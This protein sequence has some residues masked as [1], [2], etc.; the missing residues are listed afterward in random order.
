MK[1]ACALVM[2]AGA[3]HRFGR[4]KIWVPILGKPLLEW[5]LAPFLFSPRVAQVILIVREDHLERCARYLG[6]SKVTAVV[7]GGERRQQSVQNGLQ[8]AVLNDQEYLL[9]HDGARPG[10]SRTLLDRVLDSLEEY[11]AVVPALS[12]QETVKRCADDHHVLETLDRQQIWLAQTP[13]GFHRDVLLD[14]YKKGADIVNAPDDAFL[15]EKA[16]YR[17]QVIEGDPENLKVTQPRDLHL[18]RSYLRQRKP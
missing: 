17:V 6:F 10:V 5:S 12:A 4:E 3:S 2:A 16:G 8:A 13:Q 18:V 11:P 15:V 14:A 7:A 1:H 9:V